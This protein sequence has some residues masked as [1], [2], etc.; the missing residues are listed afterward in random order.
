MTGVLVV[1]SIAWDEVVRLGE[2]LRVG[3]HN[4]GRDAG[5]RI[6]GGG[7]NS[8][9]ALARAGIAV[10]VVSAVGEN[11]DGTELVERLSGMGVGVSM[12][13]RHAGPTTRSLVLLD[14]HGERTVVNLARAALRLPQGLEAVQAGCVYVRSSE[15]EL[16][17]FL[18]GRRQQG[19][20]IAHIPPLRAYARAA[21]VLVGSASDLDD[22]FLAAPF[23]AGQAVAGDCLEW[24]VITRGADG[25]VAY[26]RDTVLRQPAPTVPVVDSTGA[27][28]VFAAGLAAALAQGQ[29]MAQALARAVQWGS[30]S[31]SYA[32][33][34]PPEH[35]PA[36]G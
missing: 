11:G 22:D 18:Q 36:I 29:E 26:G 27:G 10:E 24:V 14:E 3:S 15:P 2:P 28:D 5:R 31:V 6:G 1:G 13:G 21:Q 20:V 17:H 35:F 8:A 4:S 7:A 19:W 32:G 33:T 9:M 16:S 23:A 25:A 34:V 12:V 30:A